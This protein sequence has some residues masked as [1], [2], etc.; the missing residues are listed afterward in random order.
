MVWLAFKGLMAA[1]PA[2]I[3]IEDA[4][5]APRP[6]GGVMFFETAGIEVAL[7]VPPLVALVLSFF[8]S[9]GGVSGACLLLPFQ[10]SVLGYTAPS[11]SATN[12]L[13]NVVA[14]PGGVFRYWREGRMV[15]PLAAAIAAG[16]APGVVAGA[17][18]RVAWLEDPRSFKLFVAVVLGYIGLRLVHGLLL[19]GGTTPGAAGVAAAVTVPGAAGSAH[20]GRGSRRGIAYVYGG[21]TYRASLSGV[22]ALSGLVGVVGGIYG[23]GGGAIV[24]PFLVSAF[25]L[26]V[27]TVAGPALLGTFVTSVV[28]VACY[29]LLAPFHPGLSVAPDW[30][31]GLLF[32]AGGL[33]G[34][35]LGAR[36]Q[37]RVPARAITWMLAVITLFIAARYGLGAR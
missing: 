37:K 6:L 25:R 3:L 28:G 12:Q 33:V 30:L 16:S 19:R 5:A 13:F 18:V 9:M 14:T 22:L 35:Y 2:R 34:T 11:V 21:V 29:A 36:V 27:H 31:L 10:M 1:A 7:W 24:A 32:G 20:A 17:L 4:V 15:W 8:T 26:P 23:I